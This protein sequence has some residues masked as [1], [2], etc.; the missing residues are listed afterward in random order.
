MTNSGSIYRQ[1]VRSN[2]SCCT[3]GERKKPKGNEDECQCN[4]SRWSGVSGERKKP[5]GNEDFSAIRR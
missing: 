2:I 1:N 5:K 4:I 3:S